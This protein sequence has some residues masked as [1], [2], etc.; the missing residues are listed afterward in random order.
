MV[1]IVTLGWMSMLNVSL[2]ATGAMLF[3][4]Y[5]TLKEAARSIG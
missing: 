2:L 5:L 3:T 1:V 4:G